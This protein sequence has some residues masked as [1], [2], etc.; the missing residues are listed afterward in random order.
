MASS[1]TKT[2][3]SA[4]LKMG[5]KKQ[6]QEQDVWE[7]TLE[8]YREL[9]RRFDTIVVAF[10][11]GKD[12]TV[13]IQAAL[14]VAHEEPETRLPLKAYFFD[15][16]AIHPETVDYVRRMAD[17]PD[18]EMK[19]LCIPVKHR[20]GCSRIE[21]WWYCWEPA[22]KDVWC[23]ELPHDAITEVEGFE[24]GMTM[25]DVVPMLY[26]PEHG[27]V[28]RVLGLR[29][30]ESLN[31]YR[32]VT[33]RVK[34]NWFHQKD[35]NSH[36]WYANPIYD[37]STADVWTAPNLFDWDYNTLYDVLSMMG[38]SAHIQRVSQAFGEEPMQRMYQY[39]LGWPHL[40]DK[41][42]N[43]VAGARTAARYS[44]TE[45]YGFGGMAL[46]EG[47]SWRSWVYAQMKLYPKKEQ[48]V[49]AK[50]LLRQ[51]NRHR[52]LTDNSPMPQEEPDIISGLSWRFL[53][54]MMLRG[55]LKNRKAGTLINQARKGLEEQGLT[56]EEALQM[57]KEEHNEW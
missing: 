4:G 14:E 12:S 40:W 57:R 10:S 36:F 25:M 26:G 24:M 23:R 46:P 17:R 35:N 13:L 41:M 53:C 32:A 6:D 11:G 50:S 18:V 56:R 15:E 20:N 8:R 19:W 5:L 21:P 22:K 38:V 30:A 1:N 9:Y 52:Q 45:L 47:H 27:T 48:K 49:M 39:Q 42:T 44:K 55:D 28:C 2:D 43:R 34:D 16:E 54:M 51:I 3:E 7:A 31:R 29:A 33:S 37:W